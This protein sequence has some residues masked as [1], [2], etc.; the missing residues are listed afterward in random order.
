[1]HI[2]ED[3][4]F[5]CVDNLPPALL[6]KFAELC[7]HSNGRVARAAVA[8]DV[9]GGV[10]FDEFQQCLEDL[11]SMGA[12]YHILFLE[13]S[14]EVLV[15]RFKETRRRHPL[16]SPRRSLLASIR[17]ERRLLSDVRGRADKVIDTSNLPVG[18]LRDEI[19]SMFVAPDQVSPML[20]SVVNFG[21]K[22]GVPV[23]ADLV[24]D[25]RFLPNPHYVPALR[26]KTGDSPEVG[27]FV[28]SSEGAA[29]FL[30]RLYSLLDLCLPLYANEGKAYLTIALGCTGGRH[31]SVALGAQL[32]RHLRAKGCRVRLENRDIKK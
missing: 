14:E 32:A 21:F 5:F 15:K 9:R 18:R 20:V 31:R 19:Q 24:F 2:L 29:E 23:D 11:T 10:F 4:G 13:A 7:A 3:A 12:Q 26:D 25:V 28:L 8:T 16:S 17:E 30:Q 6:T 22:Y 27:D 1:M